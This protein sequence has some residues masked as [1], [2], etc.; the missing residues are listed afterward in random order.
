MLYFP[1]YGKLG[2]LLTFFLAITLL[3]FAAA[4]FYSVRKYGKPHVPA[5]E[6]EHADPGIPL[7][8]KILYGAIALYIIAATAWVASTGMKI[9]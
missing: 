2:V 7:V 4:I 6:D 1:L 8:L 3:L 9:G 5:S